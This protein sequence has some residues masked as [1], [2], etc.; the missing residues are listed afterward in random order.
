MHHLIC[1]KLL[2]SVSVK[3]KEFQPAH[4]LIKRNIPSASCLKVA[5]WQAA[6]GPLPITIHYS[7]KVAWFSWGSHICRTIHHPQ[8]GHKC[9]KSCKPAIK[10]QLHL[11]FSL[12]SFHTQSI[13]KYLRWAILLVEGTL[14]ELVAVATPARSHSSF[15]SPQSFTGSPWPQHFPSLTYLPPRQEAAEAAQPS[16][17]RCD[18]ICHLLSS[19]ISS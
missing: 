3:L 6:L 14:T 11:G 8:S 2:T 18:W 1:L 9:L 19:R 13:F 5:G 4:Y 15:L 10:S 16:A 7:C 17:R 12:P